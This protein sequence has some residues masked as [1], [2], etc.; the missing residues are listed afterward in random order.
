VEE[1]EARAKEHDIMFIETSA[2]AGFNIKALFRKVASALP[3]MENTAM[4]KGND[5]FFRIF[6]DSFLVINVTLPNP[7]NTGVDPNDPNAS[8]CRC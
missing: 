5:G 1:G 3:G 2:K 6:L 7:E 8:W 4:A